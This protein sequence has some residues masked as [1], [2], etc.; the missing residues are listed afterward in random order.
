MIKLKN[1]KAKIV[2]KYRNSLTTQGN[3]G[4]EILEKKVYAYGL[5]TRFKT[6]MIVTHPLSL[7]RPLS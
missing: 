4:I 6:E 1:R 7:T 2:E 3:E 5:I